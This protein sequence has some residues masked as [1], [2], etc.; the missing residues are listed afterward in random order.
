M[1]ASYKAYIRLRIRSP[2]KA[3]HQVRIRASLQRCR[4]EQEIDPALAAEARLHSTQRLKAAGPNPINFTASQAAEKVFGGDRGDPSGA[5]ARAYLLRLNGT[6]GTRAL[7]KTEFS[8]P[9]QRCRPEQEIDPALQFAEKLDIKH[10]A[11]KGAIDCAA[12]AVS[13]KRYS[14]TKQLWYR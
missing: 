4:H 14:D 5:E 3:S 12:V 13:L 11:P 7:P 1:R 6:S 2:Y 10:P 9:V 8:R